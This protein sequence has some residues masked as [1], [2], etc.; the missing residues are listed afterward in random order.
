MFKLDLTDKT[1]VSNW[2]SVNDGVMGGRSRGGV[3][4]DDGLVFEGEIN[5]NGG[6]FSSIRYDVSEGSL[7]G[8][9]GLRFNVKADKRTYKATLRTDVTYNGRQIS[10]QANIPTSGSGDWEIVEVKFSDLEA[11]L[12][13][14][15]VRGA[16]F[17]PGEVRSI[18][19]IIA[20][21]IDGPFRLKVSSIEM[22]E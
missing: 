4:F 21:N 11:S 7:E 16:R 18:G 12:F 2:Y 1:T 15:S 19:I 22:I 13:G 9:S 5:T 17:D 10:F 6:G 3:L 20:D 14:R 8:A